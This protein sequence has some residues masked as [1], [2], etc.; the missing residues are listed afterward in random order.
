VF[1]TARC[2]LFVACAAL[3]AWPG[4]ARA[5]SAAP[6]S[7]GR[8]ATLPP[9]PWTVEISVPRGVDAGSAIRDLE[10]LDLFGLEM[11]EIRGRRVV[12]L[13]VFTDESVVR[14]AHEQLLTEGFPAAQIIRHPGTSTLLDMAVEIAND[15]SRGAA[16]RAISSAVPIEP[17]VTTRTQTP[18]PTRTPIQDSIATP[19]AVDPAPSTMV[20]ERT[21]PPARQ[22]RGSV[23]PYLLTGVAVVALIA[24]AVPLWKR[25]SP[26]NIP[27]LQTMAVPVQ[28][29]LASPQTSLHVPPVV[30]VPRAQPAVQ[31]SATP[32]AAPPPR[33]TVSAAQPS[34]API[35]AEDFNPDQAGRVP[36][37]WMV[38][39]EA[40]SALAISAEGGG[41]LIF[42]KQTT[43]SRCLCTRTLPACHGRVVFEFDLVCDACN[44][45]LLAVHLQEGTDASRAIQTRIVTGPEGGVAL[46]LH[47][48]AIPVGWGE[49]CRIRYD[50]DLETGLLTAR[51]NGEE[52]LESHELL[53]RPSRLDAI[54][55]RAAPNTI[56]RLGL[57]RLR[58]WG[59]REAHSAPILNPN[60]SATPGHHGLS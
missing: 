5:Q 56:G 18:P 32:P 28:R 57:R 3:L 11:H 1:S 46:W 23:I 33:R 26:A 27:E 21:V 13:G 12:L 41:S 60:A 15:A 25:L 54:V 29:R 47:S 7:W 36:S 24:V 10:A 20:A 43:S 19:P 35:F 44:G 16:T 37:A 9:P 52:V 2:L 34:T 55:L 50:V 17:R 42:D 49:W 14:E 6:A 48:G 40:G 31:A 51:L 59:S 30:V 45:H 4:L 39:A 8:Q 38:G 58:A 22:S 53:V